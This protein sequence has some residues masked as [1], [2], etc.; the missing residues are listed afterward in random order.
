M[1]EKFGTAVM[2]ISHD[3]GTIGA[4]SSRVAVFYA[5]RIIEQGAAEAVLQSPF[6]P[7]TRA[8][9]SSLPS[10]NDTVLASLSGQP[11]DLTQPIQGCSFAPRC[12]VR[13]SRWEEDPKSEPIATGQLVDC[14]RALDPNLEI[15]G[16]PAKR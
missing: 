2:L 4:L 15:V 13:C 10:K 11:P 14:W 7:Y 12:P 16:D 6:H 3:I 8:L 9:L 1:K 5:G